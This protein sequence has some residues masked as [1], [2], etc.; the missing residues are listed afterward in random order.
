MHP[1][2]HAASR[3]D[4]PAYL[5]A[6]GGEV[7]TYRQLNDRSNQI[8]QLF[9]SLGLKRGDGIA[10]FSENNARYFEV[11]WAAQRTG[12]HY[13]CIASRLTEAEV[14][15]ILGDSGAQVFIASPNLL[16]VARRV[17]GKLGVPLYVLDG[18][19]PEV[20]S[21]QEAAATF[22]AVPVA[23]ESH[24]RDMLYSSGTT[25]RP[26]GIKTPLPDGPIDQAG[27]V[28]KLAQTLYGMDENTIY[29][30]PAPLYHAAPLRFCMDVHRLG[31]TVIV[32]ERFDPE[33]ALALID[34]HKVTHAQW[35]PTHFIRFLKLPE[36]TRTKYDF[37]SLQ[38]VF[39]AAA[40][41]PVPIKQAMME[42]WGPI[43]HEYYSSTELNGFTAVSPQEWA[44]HPGT[45]GRALIGEI[46]ICDAD[47]NA[48]PPRAI[49]QIY[50]A[51]GGD[52]TYHNDPEKTA[53]T[54]NRH[55]WTS[56]GD[57]G[58]VDE[59]GFLYLT[60]RKDFMIISGGVN[61]YPQEIENVLINHPKVADVAVVSAP[62][63][64][65]GE[66]V[67]AVVQPLD[68]SQAGSGL[69]DELLA[70]ARQ[71]LSPVKIPKLMEFSQELPRHPTGKLYK[72]LLQDAYWKRGA[73]A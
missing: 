60:D 68:W 23:D 30:S 73:G 6:A 63:D 46:R 40:P 59:E 56:V 8:A 50:F 66:M 45:V 70:Y 53:R 71:S 28:T 15:Y 18:E 12:L 27:S 65:F 41:C 4:K 33:A 62:D 58:W 17:A 16:P 36:E 54:R 49:G 43:I 34:T 2:I 38:C 20:R 7:V 10:L 13:V 31:G 72:R 52:F 47:D 21:L 57:I 24:G 42:W 35:V 1:F 48:L 67:V 39:H 26:K 3:P 22:P 64:E 51:N 37:S 9:R 69:R 44:A 5:M 32:M 55:G 61:I 14:E 19:D 11:T 25:G 29:L